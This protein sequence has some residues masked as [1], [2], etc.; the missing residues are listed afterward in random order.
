MYVCIVSLVSFDYFRALVFVNC[1]LKQCRIGIADITLTH[2]LFFCDNNSLTH[3]QRTTRNCA[4]IY[5]GEGASPSLDQLRIWTFS[6]SHLCLCV[7]AHRPLSY[8]NI[9]CIY[10]AVICTTLKSR[11]LSNNN[12]NNNSNKNKTKQNEEKTR[13]LVGHRIIIS[14]VTRKLF[15]C[16]CSLIGVVRTNLTWIHLKIYCVSWV[17]FAFA[18]CFVPDEYVR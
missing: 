1:E 11:W 5:F 12:N 16:C 7:G 8:Y 15:C 17:S 14:P 4:C 18:V 3:T 13:F 10:L 6:L 2:V 9:Q